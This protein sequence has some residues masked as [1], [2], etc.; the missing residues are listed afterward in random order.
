MSNLV[1]GLPVIGSPEAKVLLVEFM[2]FGCSHCKNYA[3]V[4]NTI[5]KEQVDTGKARLAMVTL[6]FDVE[7]ASFFAAN[8]A[9]CADQQGGYWKMHDA[10]YELQ[11]RQGL[12]WAVIEEIVTARDLDF[13]KLQSC[14][15][16]QKAFPVLE[17]GLSM[18]KSAKISGTPTLMYSLDGGVTLHYFK[19]NGQDFP[20]GVTAQMVAELIA[21]NP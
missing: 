17:S 1:T 19:V 3:P 15:T 8:V 5:I 9:I 21:Q 18:A 10:L 4:I 13:P 12:S 16:E 14:V 20:S 2:N 7:D 11:G 6:F